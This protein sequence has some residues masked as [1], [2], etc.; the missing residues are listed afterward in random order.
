MDNKSIEY[1][2]SNNLIYKTE[3]SIVADNWTS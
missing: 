2:Y 1:N 3:L